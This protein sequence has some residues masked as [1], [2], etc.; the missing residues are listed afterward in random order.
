MIATTLFREDDSQRVS[1]MAGGQTFESWQYDVFNNNGAPS[2][3]FVF[4]PGYGRD[5]VNLFRAG[6][7]DHDT[8]SLK[9][10]DFGNSIAA[11]LQNTHRLPGGGSLIVDPTSGDAVRLTGITKAQLVH[12]QSDI[13]FH[14]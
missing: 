11:V 7:A 3:T 2:S 1:V 4:D 14:A 12:N 6:G 8:V 5:V 10:S 13:A 9:G